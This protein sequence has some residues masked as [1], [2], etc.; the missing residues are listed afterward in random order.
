MIQLSGKECNTPVSRDYLEM[1]CGYQ[2]HG[3]TVVQ[4]TE[5]KGS[6]ARLKGPG[7]DEHLTAITYLISDSTLSCLR[8]A[9]V[10]SRDVWKSGL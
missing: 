2:S 3:V 4:I 7:V 10:V 9:F 1:N 6:S 8:R 5:T